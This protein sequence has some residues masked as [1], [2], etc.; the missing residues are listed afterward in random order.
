MSVIAVLFVELFVSGVVVRRRRLKPDFF[1]LLAASQTLAVR[2]V[3]GM[4]NRR[5]SAMMSNIPHRE[6]PNIADKIRL[7]LPSVW[8][9]SRDLRIRRTDDADREDAIALLQEIGF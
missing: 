1:A 9:K 5:G 8:A 2:V 6:L 3:A 4:K 7:K